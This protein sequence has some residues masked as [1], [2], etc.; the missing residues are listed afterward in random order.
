MY[1][2]VL[3]NLPLDRS[4]TYLC[5]TP[6]P[7][8]L[9]YRVEVLFSKRRL[10]GF[11]IASSPQAPEGDFK[12]APVLRVV[13]ETPLFTSRQVEMAFW[14]AQT[15]FCGPGEALSAMLPAGRRETAAPALGDFEM[16]RTGTFDLSPEQLQGVEGIL[17]TGK[18]TGG[19]LYY[20]EGI[21]GSG[22]TEV[23]LTAAERMLKAGRGVIY[24]VPEI[25][26]SHQIQAEVEARFGAQGAILHSRLTV[27]QRYAEWMRLLRGETRLVLG[28]RSAVFAP[29]R[30]LGLIIVDEEHEGSYKSDSTPRY[31]ARQ[32]AFYRSRT[33]GARVVLGSATPSLEAYHLCRSGA[34]EHSA[35]TRRLSGGTLPAIE[36][37]N[38]QGCPHPFSQTLIDAIKDCRLRGGQAILFLNRRG[39]SH[40]FH[41]KTCGYQMVCRNCSVSLTYHKER[42]A[43]VC[44]YCGYTCPPVKVCPSCSSLDVG[45]AGFGTEQVEEQLFRIFPGIRAARLDSDQIRGKG[46][47]EAI[48]GAFR[49]GET[50]ILLG[51]QMVAKGLNFPGVRLVG[52]ILADTGLHLP[53]FR[54]AERV[55]SLLTQVAG[56]AGRFAPGGRVIIQ[57]YSPDHPAVAC[58]ARG[59]QELFYRQELE[60]RRLLGFPPYC[61]IFRI[62]FRG[63]DEAKVRRGIEDFAGEL[64]RRGEGKFE[65]LGPS[66]CPLSQIAGNYRRHLLLR[67]RRL[68]SIRPVLR[69]WLRE[70]G[71]IPGVYIE[72]DPDPTNLL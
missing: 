45:Y 57:T 22:K 55:F 39:F 21:T 53:D 34:M 11:V 16:P 65:V 29:V 30:D 44:H 46:K 43:M 61:R 56:R 54:A 69:D 42:Q 49:R 52:I 50:E 3:F 17:G 10:T 35:L 51:T 6:P 38:M 12:V 2:E 8:P 70:F 7:V 4:F 19:G 31:H 37:V 26:L 13:D 25:A 63:K 60:N 20:L 5:E 40:F 15:Y 23:F 27:S 62:N 58:A 67:A 47:L 28:A 18:E 66:E 36:V 24:L 41:C 68:G 59:E 9:G 33:E 64:R 48:L 32:V 14:L 72:V 1:L 71:K